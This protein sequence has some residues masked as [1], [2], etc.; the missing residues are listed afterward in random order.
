MKIQTKTGE[1]QER[2]LIFGTFQ[3]EKAAQCSRDEFAE[4]L[5]SLGAE[6]V[7]KGKK[8]QVYFVR[9]LDDASPHL[10]F[11]G[12]GLPGELSGETLR[13]AGAHCFKRLEAEKVKEAGLELSTLHHKE[14]NKKFNM[15]ALAHGLSQ[16]ML[17]SNYAFDLYKS[18]KHKPSVQKI[19]F[20][21]DKGKLKGAEKGIERAELEA[22]FLFLSRNLSN[23]PGSHLYPEELAK[24]TQRWAKEHGL[25]C[26]VLDVKAMEKEKMGGILGVGQGSANP[27][28][29]IVLEH[30]P[31]NAK[32]K[33]ALVGKAVTFDSG[34]ISLKP[35]QGMEDMKHD[36]SG[37][38]DV[39][40][41]TFLAAKLGCKHH[42]ICVVPA[43]ENM[44]DGKAI[45]PS[46]VLTAR[47]GKTIEVQ[48]TDA[49]GRLILSDALDYAQDFEPDA[50]VDV[51]TLTGA[52]VMALSHVAAGIMG[53]DEGLMA[54]FKAAAAETEERY[55]ELP[56]FQE[57]IDDI[58]SKIADIKNIG[59][60]KGA[61]SQKGGA[62]LKE[63]IRKGNKWLHVDIAGTAW[64]AGKVPYHPTHGATGHTVRT[65]AQLVMDF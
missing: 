50:I 55:V 34:G 43:A 37:G 46:A 10:L 17:F 58:K 26:K 42:I 14:L 65:L 61:G 1:A 27:P 16:G 21:T 47:S 59:G 45:V 4:L 56:I 52:V 25:S 36:M 29:L 49:E 33:I 9:A 11:V 15:E 57:Y 60:D 22:E 40:A 24:R 53:N 64:S 2:V 20:Y 51:A 44:P 5:T 12:L 30:K 38:A 54:K 8:G 7:F 6:D 31:K 63:F 41:A 39:I 28:C 32:K 23:E 62:F 35:G 3:G 19:N 13:V 18:E 48:N